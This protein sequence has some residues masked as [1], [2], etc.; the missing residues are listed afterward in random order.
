MRQHTAPNIRSFGLLHEDLAVRSVF[1]R[2]LWNAPHTPPHPHPCCCPHT[3]WCQIFPPLLSHRV[4]L[5]IWTE[6][7]WVEMRNLLWKY[8]W[9]LNWHPEVDAHFQNCRWFYWTGLWTHAH[10]FAG[11]ID[12]LLIAIRKSNQCNHGSCRWLYS[13]QWVI[14]SPQNQ[15]LI[16]W[17]WI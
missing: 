1:F 12:L 17:K 2:F 13:Y 9:E 3:Q 11:N 15:W 4:V 10:I 6:S 16:S 8:T 7:Q 5:Q 14:K